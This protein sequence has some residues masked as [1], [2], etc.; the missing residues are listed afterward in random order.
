MRKRLNAQMC[1][2]FLICCTFQPEVRACERDRRLAIISHTK[3]T[4]DFCGSFGNHGSFRAFEYYH[5]L[6]CS[7]DS[8]L[9]AGSLIS[10]IPSIISHCLL[11]LLGLSGRGGSLKSPYCSEKYL[12]MHTFK[13]TRSEKNN[14]PNAVHISIL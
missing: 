13:I 5:L 1:L 8:I 7:I 2:H 6:N 12:R 14:G 4:M 10:N 9:L 11:H 3:H